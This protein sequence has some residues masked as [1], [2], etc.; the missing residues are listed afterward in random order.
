MAF[1]NYT[2]IPKMGSNHAGS[3]HAARHSYLETRQNFSTFPQRYI[4]SATND[5]TYSKAPVQ[6]FHK[7]VPYSTTT[8][9]AQVS[10]CIVEVFHRITLL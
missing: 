6:M 3:Y 8:Y 1:E 4:G 10:S 2:Y 5:S 7:M 9:A